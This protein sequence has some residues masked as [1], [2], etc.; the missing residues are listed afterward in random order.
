MLTQPYSKIDSP[1]ITHPITSTTG[2]PRFS[3]TGSVPCYSK[4]HQTIRFQYRWGF[5]SAPPSPRYCSLFTWLPYIY[6]IP[7][8]LPYHM[9]KI[10]PSQPH[11]LQLGETSGY[12]K[13]QP[14]IFN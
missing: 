12:S 6:L 11:P 5:P 10:S 2:L 7:Q 8:M 4:V 9:S 14:K 3:K 1:P 13:K